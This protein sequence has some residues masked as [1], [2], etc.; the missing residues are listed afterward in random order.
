MGEVKKLRVGDGLVPG[1][2]MGPLITS[3]AAGEVKRKVEDAV[4]G[5]SEVLVGGERSD[6][7]A[8]QLTT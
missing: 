3:A 2:S 4:S 7:R 1:I 6:N 8:C 5:G